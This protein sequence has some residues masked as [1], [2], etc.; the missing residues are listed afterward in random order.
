M[1]IRNNLL[2]EGIKIGDAEAKV[3][4]FADDTTVVLSDTDSALA[5]FQALRHFETL[6][7][8]KVNS[9]KAEGLWICLQKK[10]YSKPLGIKWPNEPIKALGIFFTYDNTLLYEKHFRETIVNVKKNMNI[11]S[12]RGLSIFGKIVISFYGRVR[13]HK[14]TRL[15]TINDYRKRGLKMINLN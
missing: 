15:P 1:A 6:S 7:R 13:V 8:L 14:V 9:S 11:W 5:L 3:L 4:Q 10:N 12:S 2:I